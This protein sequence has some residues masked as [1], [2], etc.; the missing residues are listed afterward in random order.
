MKGKSWR[1]NKNIWKESEKALKNWDSLRLPCSLK[2]PWGN[3]P[4]GN[5]YKILDHRNN[6]IF[7]W[8]LTSFVSD[9]LFIL[10]FFWKVLTSRKNHMQFHYVLNRM[11]RN[12]A[13][14]IKIWYGKYFRFSFDSSSSLSLSSLLLSPSK[15]YLNIIGLINKNFYS[16]EPNLRKKWFKRDN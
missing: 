16:F 6:R 7:L 8:I 1:M 10:P 11:N 14:V 13:S 9:I 12:M 5:P 2:I 3:I 4:Q 15:R